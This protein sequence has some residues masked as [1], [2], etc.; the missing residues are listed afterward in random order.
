[1]QA[2]LEGASEVG[3]TW[4]REAAEESVGAE[5]VWWISRGLGHYLSYSVHIDT[6][7]SHREMVE[8]KRALI[9]QAALHFCTL[10]KYSSMHCP[11]VALLRLRREC[12]WAK[13]CY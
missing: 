4:E 1:M 9:Y 13:A 10:H 5:W 8:S 2:E 7:V 12:L 6:C 11:A 3:D